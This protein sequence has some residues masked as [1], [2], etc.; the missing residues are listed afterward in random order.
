VIA[1]GYINTEM[2]AAVPKEVLNTKILPFIPVGRLGTAE[3]V[4]RCV[5]F[6][7]SDDAGFITGAVIDVNGGQYMA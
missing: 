3:E 5:I 7:A 6:L 4:A 1:P 2:V